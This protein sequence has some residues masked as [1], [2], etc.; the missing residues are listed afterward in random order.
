[1]P[2]RQA[3]PRFTVELLYDRDCGFC[4]RSAALLARLDRR[5]RV[6]VVPLQQAG[7]PAHFGVT[8]DQALEQ[9]WALDSSGG[10]HHGAGA[11]NAALSGVLG[12]RIPLYFY[13][14]WG[15]RQIQDAAYRTVATNRHR[16][17][18]KGGSC[19]VDLDHG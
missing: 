7:A 13:R 17:P 5:G 18:G 16:L 4:V 9:A 10:R 19:A 14:I 11:V 12:S 1:M 15:I 8:T 6:K 3:A 2:D